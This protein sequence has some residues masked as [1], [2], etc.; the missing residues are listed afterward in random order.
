MNERRWQELVASLRQGEDV[1]RMVAAA[2]SLQSEATAEDV[3]K[4]VNLL[5]DENF[6][7]RE[8]AAWPLS[9]LGRTEALPQLLRAYQRGLDEGHDNDGFSTALIDLFEMNQS[10]AAPVL[11]ELSGAGESG[12]AETASWLLTFGKQEA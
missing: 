6:F 9:E 3:P 5:E 10:A 2:R 12:I 8:A 4:L 1:E 7:V 11:R